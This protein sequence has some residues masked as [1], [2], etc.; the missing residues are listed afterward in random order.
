VAVPGCFVV[1][2]FCF[3]KGAGETHWLLLLLSLMYL[4]FFQVGKD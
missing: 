3:V 2:L 1:S 4:L